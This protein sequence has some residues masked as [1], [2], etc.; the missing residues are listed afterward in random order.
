[1][2]EFIVKLGY[3]RYKFNNKQD[4]SIFAEIAALHA[5]DPELD[6]RIEIVRTLKEYPEDEEELREGQ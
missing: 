3:G 4:A 5:V 2:L 1:M 6:V